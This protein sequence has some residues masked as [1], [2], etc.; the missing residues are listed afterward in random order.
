MQPDRATALLAVIRIISVLGMSFGI[1]LGIFLL[2][3][4]W[5]IEG[6]ISLVAAVP[7][8]TV[9]RYMEKRAADE[10]PGTE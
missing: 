5:W 1:A 4:A 7:F 10:A 9:M 8:F 3:G 2:L 6:L